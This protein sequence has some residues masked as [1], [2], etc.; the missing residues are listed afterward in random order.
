MKRKAMNE[1]ETL[2]RRVDGVEREMEWKRGSPK[3][4]WM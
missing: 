4:A 3:G 2:A 1:I